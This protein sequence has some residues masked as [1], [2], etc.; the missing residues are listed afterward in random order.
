M[1]YYPDKVTHSRIYKDEMYEYKH[2]L[3]P[4]AV[5]KGMEKNR[6]LTEEEI[7]SLGIIHSK[8]WEHYNIFKN[9]PYVLLFRRR[10]H[11]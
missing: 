5:F 8:D 6:L 4:K 10:K 11:S 7:K 2:V 1:P 3:L 9:E